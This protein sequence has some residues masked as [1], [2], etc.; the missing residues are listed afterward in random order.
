MK[1]RLLGLSGEFAGKVNFVEVDVDQSPDLATQYEADAIP[2]VIIFKDG[3]VVTELAN[4]ST[5]KYRD[6]LNAAL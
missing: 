4:E 2:K 1:Q 5:D 3:K 6:K